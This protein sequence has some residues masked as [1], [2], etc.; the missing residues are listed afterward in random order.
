MAQSR[1]QGDAAVLMQAKTL[2]NM[3]DMGANLAK[4]MDSAQITASP[5]I[6][7]PAKGNFI[8]MLM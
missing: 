2:Q 6:T 8:N 1:V 5:G 4:L 3:K 7:D